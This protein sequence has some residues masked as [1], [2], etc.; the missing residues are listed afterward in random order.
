[1]LSFVFGKSAAALWFAIALT[2]TAQLQHGGVSLAQTEAEGLITCLHNFGSNFLGEVKTNCKGVAKALNGAIPNVTNLNPIECARR[3]SFDPDQRDWLEV[4][5]N[6]KGVAKALMG[7]IPNV[8]N[9]IECDEIYDRGWLSVDG[10]QQC[11]DTARALSILIADKVEGQGF[12]AF[13]AAAVPITGL[14]TAGSGYYVYYELGGDRDWGKTVLFALFVGFRIFD[15]MG[16][17]G[18]YSISLAGQHKNT[19]LRRANLAFSII[20][21]LLLALDL[22]TMRGRAEHWFGI[23]TAVESVKEIGY[24]MLAVVV[25]ED[26]PQFIITIAFLADVGGTAGRSVDGIAVTSLIFSL[27]S[28]VGNAILAF[29]SIG[30]CKQAE[31]TTPTQRS[32]EF[33]LGRTGRNRDQ[34]SETFEGFGV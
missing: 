19:P 13:F 24:G 14:V 30:C 21:T 17:W 26:A 18:M 20:G 2:A 3:P 1:M 34:N 31:E 23:T 32:I 16:D 29:R 8:T 27:I 7:A 12:K 9:P 5:T 25:F 4:K 6:C 33:R 15:L 10:E 22:K 28:M 11:D